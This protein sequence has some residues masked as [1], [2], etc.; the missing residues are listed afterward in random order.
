MHNHYLHTGMRREPT[1]RVQL[2]FYPKPGIHECG[3]VNVLR[4]TP[5]KL[6]FPIWG[7]P[8]KPG[9]YSYLGTTFLDVRC[10][11]TPLDT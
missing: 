7:E 8:P 5:R 4:A 9:T 10:T 1:S 2:Y 11:T 6:C 3:V